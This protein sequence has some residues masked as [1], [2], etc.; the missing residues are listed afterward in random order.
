MKNLEQIRAADAL[1][2]AKD[3]NRSAVNRLPALIL[4]NGLLATIAFCHGDSSGDNRGQM[5]RALLATARYLHGQN[6]LEAEHKKLDAFASDL[7]RRNSLHLQHVTTEALAFIGYLR[8][9]AQ[10]DLPSN[11]P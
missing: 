3:L 2:A 10:K 9:F 6:L 7:S 4:G 1:P 8:R 11:N 5:A